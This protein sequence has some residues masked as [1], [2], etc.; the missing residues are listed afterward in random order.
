MGNVLTDVTDETVDKAH[1]LRRIED[2]QQRLHGLY[3][4]IAEWLPDEWTVQTQPSVSM[5]EGLMRKFDIEP[6]QLPILNCVNGKGAVVTLEPRGLWIIGS[7]GRVD[8]KCGK[9]H[10]LIVD[11]AENFETPK[12]QA[13]PGDHRAERRAVSRDW[14]MSI[15]P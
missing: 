13:A 15:L 14:L 4:M 7:N 3:G 2:W 1:V 5:H 12:W 6:R 8:L 9:K 11:L 10:Y